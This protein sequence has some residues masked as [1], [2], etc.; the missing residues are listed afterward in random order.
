MAIVF[1]QYSYVFTEAPISFTILSSSSAF[2]KEYFPGFLPG[3]DLVVGLGGTWWDLVGLGGTWE[4]GLG[5]TWWGIRKIPK[6]ESMDC[7]LC[8][9][10]VH[11]LTLIPPSVDIF[12]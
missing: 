1:L 12:V 11:N 9:R 4:V 6:F 10:S 8:L 2:L 7:E 3:W 5:G